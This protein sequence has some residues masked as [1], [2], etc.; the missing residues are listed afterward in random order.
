MP[1]PPGGY[2]PVPQPQAAAH[3]PVADA[4]GDWRQS[5]GPLA[6]SS[7]AT[8][9]T[10]ERKTP[11]DGIL[12]QH[13]APFD[14]MTLGQLYGEG[15]YKLY[16]YDPGQIRA[17]ETEIRIGPSFGAPKWPQQS[18]Q[19]RPRQSFM[20]PWDRGAA[21]GAPEEGEGHRSSFLRQGY[22]QP[23]DDGRDRELLAFA[24]H[25]S[26]AAESSA[27]EAI[28]A[29]GQISLENMKQATEARK[30]GPESSL[31]EFFKSQHALTEKRT[32]DERERDAQRRKD[33]EEKWERRQREERAAAERHEEDDRKRHERELERI[34]QE[35]ES[36]YKQIQAETESRLK[37]AQA[38]EESR[39]KRLAEDRKTSVELED[40]KFQNMREES[41]I[42]REAL[43]IELKRSRE[44]MQRVQDKTSAEIKASQE[45]VT[46]EVKDMRDRT[47]KEITA[48]RESVGVDADRER[49]GLDRE[50]KLREKALDRE[51][52]LQI[53]I[54]EAREESLSKEGGDLVLNTIGTIAK[55]IAKGFERFVDLKKIQAT[56][57]MSPEAQ[58]AAIERGSIDGNVLD[59]NKREKAPPA[60]AQGAT[61]GQAPSG[62]GRT[63]AEPE[64]EVSMD[65]IIQGMLSEPF[66]KEVI[67]EWSLHVDSGSDPTSFA[68]LYLEWMRDP[69][70]DKGRKACAAFATY[71]R[72]RNWEK[73]FRALKP[74]L[75]PETV[76]I[77]EKEPDAADFYEGFRAMVVE[78][79]RV[80]WEEFLAARKAQAAGRGPAD[81]TGTEASQGTPL[82]TRESLRA[83]KQ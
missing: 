83:V 43:E 63:E 73:M 57:D 71:M 42:Q 72:P 7:Q 51:H 58:A 53:K 32:T 46:A 19:E 18:R 5:G 34:R 80:Y 54:L 36:R 39:A 2:A 47:E 48:T 82:P 74:H 14:E 77:F 12:G 64:G 52:E 22:E 25:G 44:E 13:T 68:N 66:F 8:R 11:P 62:N 20:R 50:H 60:P 23:R 69:E 61:A 26:V 24:R 35:A 40:K 41:R 55:E 49:E 33:E 38:E 4:F 70:D 31:A 15:L 67:Q 16:R 29:L 45:R 6:A 30:S 78:Q 28:K 3:P 27:N 76:R 79:I 1:I 65:K 37:F 10:V 9:Y 75:D 81:E 17:V 59:V 56:A 21:Q